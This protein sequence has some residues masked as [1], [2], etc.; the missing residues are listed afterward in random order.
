MGL[1]LL[2]M[3]EV[4]FL[5]KASQEVLNVYGTQPLWIVHISESFSIFSA[6]LANFMFYIFFM[7]ATMVNFPGDHSISLSKL[8]D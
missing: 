8:S 3:L 7:G 6:R 5:V 1:P 2:F 4:A